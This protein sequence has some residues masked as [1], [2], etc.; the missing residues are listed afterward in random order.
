MTYL[1]ALLPLARQAITQPREAADALLAMNVPKA[2][3]WPAFFLMVILSVLLMYVAQARDLAMAAG[4]MAPSP[5]V[6]VL[7]T[8]AIS[9]AY[10]AALWKV[11]QAMGGKGSFDDALLLTV[12]VQGILF[13]AQ[14]VEFLLTLVVPPVGMVFSLVLIVAAVWINVNFV[15]A[16]HGFP[17]L[18]KAFG[19]LLLASLG[20]AILMVFLL[21]LAGLG[22]TNV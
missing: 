21:S 5:F 22:M 15:A 13:A 9:I 3:L 17:S 4:G 18:M 16:L 1:E 6:M 7:A 10:V 14:I 8:C 12:F 11:G 20:V 19:V 2:A